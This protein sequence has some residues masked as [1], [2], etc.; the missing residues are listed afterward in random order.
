MSKRRI[1]LGSLLAIAAALPVAAPRSADARV[2]IGVGFGFPAFGFGYPYYYPPPVLYAPPPVVYAPPPVYGYG[3]GVPPVVARCL[4]TGVTCP[5][6]DAR[7]VGAACGCPDA[8]GRT[9]GGRV[10]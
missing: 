2:F 3:Y 7:P 10:G 6:R 4:A 1:L 9:V 8:Y 5:L